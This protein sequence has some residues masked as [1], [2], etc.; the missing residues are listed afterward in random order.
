LHRCK[1][2]TRDN[3]SS[4]CQPKLG[5]EKCKCFQEEEYYRPFF[6]M[7]SILVEHC[8]NSYA[9][10]IGIMSNDI[11]KRNSDVL[12]DAK[13][14]YHVRQ[15]HPFFLCYSG[16]T[17][18]S[19][20]LVKTC[21]RVI[22]RNCDGHDISLLL[23]EATFDDDERGKKEAIQRRH[24]TVSEA[25]DIADQVGAKACLL[26]HFSNRYHK[27]PPG[28]ESLRL[29]CP[30]W[31][32]DQQ[33]CNSETIKSEVAPRSCYEANSHGLYV[34]FAVDGMIVPLT[35]SAMQALPILA[36]CVKDILSEPLKLE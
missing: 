13:K 25:L 4:Y 14:Q 22:R 23:H 9:L 11:M 21:Q 3:N 16:D 31:L 5:Q 30:P 12:Y 6:L 35:R 24:S 17:R 26:T 27:L 8:F 29:L 34:G 18:P 32:V 36:L 7:R 15:P 20:F 28:I 33:C 1:C 2:V 10:L 19:S